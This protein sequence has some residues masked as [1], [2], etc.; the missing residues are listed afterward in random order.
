VKY[1]RNAYKKTI[2]SRKLCVILPAYCRPKY[3]YSYGSGLGSGHWVTATG[4]GRVPG[5]FVWPGSSSGTVYTLHRQYTSFIPHL[6]LQIVRHKV[7]VTSDDP[8]TQTSLPRRLVYCLLLRRRLVHRSRP[9][10][11]IN[12]MTKFRPEKLC[13]IVLVPKNRLTTNLSK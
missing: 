4:S 11:T 6:P 13:H 8:I 2:N 1:H 9:R 7:A 3:F 5:Q 12:K 10:H